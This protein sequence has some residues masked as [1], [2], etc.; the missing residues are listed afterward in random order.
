MDRLLKTD[1]GFRHYFRSFWL[2]LLTFDLSKVPREGARW[3]VL[4]VEDPKEWANHL[5]CDAPLVFGPLQSLFNFDPPFAMPL[6]KSKLLV[7]SI[8]HPERV[9]LPPQFST[10]LAMLLFLQSE[11]YIATADR[12]F[13]TKVMDLCHGYYPGSEGERILR[14]ETLAYLE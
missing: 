6:S 8:E 5:C 10:S 11:R 2:P 7:S 12:E 3:R 13:L 4:D 9:E 14:G 1:A